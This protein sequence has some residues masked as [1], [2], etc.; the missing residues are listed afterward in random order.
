M[1]HVTWNLNYRCDLWDIKESAFSS[2]NL[3]SKIV[4]KYQVICHN[5]LSFAFHQMI[6]IMKKKWQMKLKIISYLTVGI[7]YENVLSATKE[8]T[9]TTI[10]MKNENKSKWALNLMHTIYMF[11]CLF[12]LAWIKANETTK[13]EIFDFHFINLKPTR[14][15]WLQWWIFTINCICIAWLTWSSIWI[16]P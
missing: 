6:D 3:K 9:T 13:K 10:Q 16:D 11:F 12:T 14:S 4:C 8:K 5:M 15:F 2:H 7:W 1:N